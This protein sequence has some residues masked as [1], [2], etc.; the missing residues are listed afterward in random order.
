MVKSSFK[1]FFFLCIGFIGEGCLLML[2]NNVLE[3]V[4]NLNEERWIGFRWNFIKIFF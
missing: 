2:E 3:V 4:V 1:Y